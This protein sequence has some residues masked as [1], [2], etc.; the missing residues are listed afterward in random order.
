ME[1]HLRQQFDLLLQEATGN[2]VE[3]VV[4]RCG[5]PENALALLQTDPESE[6]VWVGE[7]VDNWFAEQLLDS[8]AG[9][10]FVLDAL[11]RRSVP[12]DPGGPAGEVVARLARAAFA[13]LLVRQATQAV[14]RQLAFS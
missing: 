8:T 9:A 12:A 14:S 4:H 6:G 1:P 11:E 3:R 5:G 2:F 7:F 10:C 13:D